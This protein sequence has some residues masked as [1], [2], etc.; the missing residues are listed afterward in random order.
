M[1]SEYRSIKPGLLVGLGAGACLAAAAYFTL[2]GSDEP[3]AGNTTAA[4]TPSATPL[5]RDASAPVDQR[6]ADLL[7]RMTLEEKVAQLT[8][9][10]ED[11]QSIMDADLNFD[12]AKAHD[13]FP[14]GIGQIARPSDRRGAPEGGPRWRSLE[15]SIAFINAVQDYAVHDTRL[16][17]PVLFHE[18]ALHGYATEDATSFPQAIALASSWDTDLVKRVNAVI[19]REVRARGVPLVLSPV[20]DIA[21]DPRWG[22]IEETFGEDPYLVGEMGVAAVR[23]LQGDSLPLAG[24]K[25]FATLKHM[26]GHGQPESGTNVGAAPFG[27]RTLREYFFPPFEQV[28]KRTHIGALMAS[29]NEIDG[30]PSHVNK[31]MLHDVLRGEWGYQGAIVSDYEAIS[32]LKTLH[33]M[34][35]DMESAAAA[36]LDAG[37]DSEMPDGR[38]YPL[39]VDAVRSG[40][41]PEAQVDRAAGK[42]LAMKFEAGL[43]ENPFG[44]VETAKAITDNDQAR[45]LALEAARKSMVLLKNDGTLPLDAGSLKTLAVIGPNAAVARLGGYSGHPTHK[46]SILDGIRH[47]LGDSVNVVHAE[48]VRI[49]K[50]DDWWA[51]KV[52]LADADKN[53]ARIRAA[54][55]VAKDAD[56]IVLVV[57]DTE[58]T[59]REGWAN[60]HLG[61]RS[62]LKL[63]GQQDELADAMFALGKPVVVVLINGRPP[64]VGHIASRA[65]ALI[66]GWYLGQEGGTAMADALFGDINPG[67]K[68]PV[69]FARNVGQLPVYYNHKPS[70][71]RGY[72]FDDKSPLFPFGYGLSYTSF[73]IGTP[74][75]SAPTIAADGSVQVAVHVKNTGARAGDEVVQLYIHDEAASVTQPVKK[76]RGFQR[77]TL[78]PGEEGTVHFTLDADDLAIWDANMQQ[79][80]E[81]GEFSIMAGGSSADLKTATLNVKG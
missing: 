75:L 46:V 56:A 13:A 63:V 36:A 44:D 27:K 28:V 76:L 57:G 74:Q 51:D 15:D 12:P 42:M 49:T 22:R 16:G 54:V 34:M 67:G 40:R 3:A 23:G 55:D 77:I 38:A 64:A 11:K 45:Q 41:V 25:V 5:Y 80:V 21:R 43:F 20:V 39:L 30:V 65:N 58:Q 81:P 71:H 24:D 59:S 66:E 6:V 48:G 79:V 4:D 78:A 7:S 10:W 60:A 18:E 47:K 14:N 37:V 33:Q 32:Q 1:A 19:A 69:T 8:T 2:S 52:V 68:L 35:P 29:Y 53:R 62:S 50:N 26:T 73:D 72:L 9:V 17:I 31:W 61:D 70:A